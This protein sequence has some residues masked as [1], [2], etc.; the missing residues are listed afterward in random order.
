MRVESGAQAKEATR[1]RSDTRTMGYTKQEPLKDKDIREPLFDFLEET[2][3]KIR[4]LEEK[5]M[6]K[7]R[8]DIVMVTPEA[9]YGIE[10]KSDADTYARLA[11]QIKDYDKYFDYNIVVVGTSHGEHISEHV[12]EYWGILTVE[13][14]DG[15]FDFYCLRRPAANPKR[16]WKRKLELLWRPELAQIQEWNKMP[17]YKELNKARVSD[18]ILERVPDKIPEEVLAR[19]V[20][21]ILFERDYSKVKET[22]E[23]YRKGEIEK[24]LETET[25]PEKRME[26]M[27]RRETAAKNLVH[28]PRKKYR[29]RRHL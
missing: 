28:K 11:D 9:L 15:V 25:D 16:K 2:Y 1:E 8:A 4:I 24:K 27:R 22:L 14:V 18:K 19:Q 3:G 13:I 6:G 5:T 17:K 26:L 29:R 21:E 10:I 23:Q 20:S 12:P 7:S